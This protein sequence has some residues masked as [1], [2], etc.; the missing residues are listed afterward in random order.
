MGLRLSRQRV[1]NGLGS[2]LSAVALTV[3]PTGAS[4][5]TLEQRA[6]TSLARLIKD[7]VAGAPVACI[8]PF[9]SERLSVVPYVGVLYRRGDTIYIARVENPRSLG[10]DDAVVFDTQESELC[11][12]DIGQSIDR[13]GSSHRVVL[14]PF[15]PYTKRN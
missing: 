5:Q 9:R 7:R 2:A 10:N 11:H 15:V 3:A 13:M 12:N 1:L 8:S 4:A 6:E 14:G